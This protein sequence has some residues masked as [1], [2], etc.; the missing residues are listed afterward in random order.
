MKRLLVGLVK[1]KTLYLLVVSIGLLVFLLQ[2][3]QP[4]FSNFSLTTPSGQVQPIA[5]PGFMQSNE[6]GIYRLTGTLTLGTYTSTLLRII[7]DD[8]IYSLIINQRP[9]DISMIPLHERR[10]Y[11]KGFTYELKDFLQPGD[12]QIEVHYMDQGGLMGI[13]ISAETSPRITLFAYL[14]FTAIALLLAIKIANACKLSIPLKV[15]FIGALLI[16][17]AY[18]SVT[19]ADVREHDLGDHIGFTEYLT[20]HWAPPP[21]D[22]AVGGAFFH[23]PLYYY[24]GAIVYKATQ[25][26]EPN[27][28]VV[29][30]RIQQVLV[31][32]YSM[33]FVLF[34]L[35]ILNEL[36]NLYRRPQDSLDTHVQE[37][38]EV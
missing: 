5:E 4:S 25:L 20:Q 31:L 29:I 8:E 32:V 26:F 27:N 6:S 38:Q 36:L 11:S 19:P 18:F 30:Y 1:S 12:N 17:L 10:D 15:L 35:L 13:V 23:P 22:Y 28:K 2:N 9:V 14:L 24:T 33:G 3:I 16:R 34:G 21:V 37:V 7:P